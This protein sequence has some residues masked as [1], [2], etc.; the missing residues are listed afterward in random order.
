MEFHRHRYAW[1]LL[2]ALA[3]LPS[4]AVADEPQVKL[5][6]GDHVVIVGNTVV[7]P[8]LSFM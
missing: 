3:F 2:F 1:L 5:E 6:K 7:S 8:N 4:L